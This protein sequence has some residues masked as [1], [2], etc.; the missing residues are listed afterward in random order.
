MTQITYFDMSD[1]HKAHLHVIELREAFRAIS[2]IAQDRNKALQI[3]IKNLQAED[4]EELLTTYL[5]PPYPTKDRRNDI[6]HYMFIAGAGYA[7][8]RDF[9]RISQSPIQNVRKAVKDGS[10][11]ITHPLNVLF[12]ADAVRVENLQNL[13]QFL[14]IFMMYRVLD[15]TLHPHV[16]YD[17]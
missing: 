1:T 16:N 17:R 14:N 4:Y 5:M 10:I 7:K 3:I 11:E 15:P 6:I 8:V 2:S 9:L 12:L 13:I